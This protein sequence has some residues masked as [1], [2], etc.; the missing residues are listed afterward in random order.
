[1]C[2]STA[3]LIDTPTV[4][5]STED[6]NTQYGTRQAKVVQGSLIH[7]LQMTLSSIVRAEDP[8]RNV[9]GRSGIKVSSSKDI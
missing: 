4:L 9:F 2:F 7:C 5:R 8:A 3:C 6:Y 1:M